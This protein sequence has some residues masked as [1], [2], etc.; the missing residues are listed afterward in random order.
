MQAAPQRK[1]LKDQLAE[2]KA[3]KK[4][5][6]EARAKKKAGAGGNGKPHANMSW[7]QMMSQA[8]LNA[9]KPYINQQIA[10][11]VQHQTQRMAG[12]VMEHIG[13]VQTRLLA[14]EK[15]LDVDKEALSLHIAEFEDEALGYLTVTGPASEGDRVRVSVLSRNADEAEFGEETDKIMIDSIGRE[16]QQGDVQTYVELEAALVGKNAGET[17]VVTIPKDENDEEG[18]D[19]V[20]QATIIRVSA[21]PVP[22]APQAAADTESSETEETSEEGAES[23]G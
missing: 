10:I 23:E 18:Q 5:K 11:G 6:K 7:E 3:A 22:E 4:A 14:L 8:Q 17:V 19:L 13:Q 21:K 9:L 12:L 20:L 1:S 15:L 16:N 2:Q